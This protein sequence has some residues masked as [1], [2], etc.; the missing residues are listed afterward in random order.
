MKNEMSRGSLLCWMSP[1]KA[2]AGKEAL[3]APRA[4][5]HK[6]KLNNGRTECRKEEGQ[7][8]GLSTHTHTPRNP[9]TGKLA[10]HFEKGV[11]W[12]KWFWEAQEQQDSTLAPASVSPLSSPQHTA[13]ASAV[14]VWQGHENETGKTPFKNNNKTNKA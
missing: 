5:V 3:W 14:L 6:D 8:S 13:G 12:S 4:S 1:N 7:C 9:N 2:K 11:P 10:L